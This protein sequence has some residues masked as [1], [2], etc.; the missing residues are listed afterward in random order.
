[1]Q[2]LCY[3]NKLRPLS[4][5]CSSF[6][7]LM[8]QQKVVAVGIAKPDVK[9]HEKESLFND[10]AP[11]TC[12]FGAIRLH[13]WCVSVHA[14]ALARH[15]SAVLVYGMRYQAKAKWRCL[16]MA[17]PGAMRQALP[18]VLEHPIGQLYETAESFRPNHVYFENCDDDGAV[19]Y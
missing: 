18:I 11:R 4:R 3:E 12:T 19:Q 9:R 13:E 16:P 10:N 2:G 15:S 1:M 8:Q 17:R 5:A 14:A 7:V 6:F